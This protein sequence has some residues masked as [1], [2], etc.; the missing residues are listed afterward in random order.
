MHALLL[1]AA[2]SM[3]C[4]GVW[5]PATT[6]Q[7]LIREF[8]RANVVRKTIYGAEGT[9]LPGTVLFDKDPQRRVEIVWKDERKRDRLEWVSIDAPSRWEPFGLRN[10]MTLA[11]VEKL[12]GRPF[13]LNGFD[14]DYGGIV[15]DWRGGALQGI[16][17]RTCRVHVTFEVIHPKKLTRAQ[18]KAIEE[19][20]GERELSSSSPHLKQLD[21]RVSNISVSY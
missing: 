5:S 6:E 1:A 3:N 21:V 19:T 16:G 10:G 4:T 18:E 13:R 2:L 9:E 7:A 11:Q 14:W 12:N 15:T 17:G 8:G 20:G